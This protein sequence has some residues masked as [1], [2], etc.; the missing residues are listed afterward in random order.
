MAIRDEIQWFKEHFAGD[1]IPKL[2]GT[3]LSFDLICA[4]AFQESGELWS[5]LRLHLARDEILRLS[6]GDTL[7]APNRSAFP[8]NKNDLIDAPRGQQMFDLAHRLLVEM[9]DATGI[10]IY[11]HLGSRP[12]KFVHGYGV[13]QYDLQ[14]FRDDPDFFLEQRWKDINACV[15]K[16]MKELTGALHQLGFSN[17]TSLTNLESVFVAIVY[18][19]GFGNFNESLGINQGHSDGTNSYGENIDQFKNRSD[20]PDSHGNPNFRR[21]GSPA[22]AGAPCRRTLRCCYREG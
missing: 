20:D 11:Q 13:F 21:R 6:V 5:K 9:G 1:V 3:P 22:V 4:I 10:E 17:K 16:L 8:K 18:N 7:D 15:A 2:A 14:F 19:T 12:D